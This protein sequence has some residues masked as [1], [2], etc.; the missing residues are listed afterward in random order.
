M[1][2]KSSVFGE[3]LLNEE[4]NF[5]RGKYKNEELSFR[6]CFIGKELDKL[7]QVITYAEDQIK[8]DFFTPMLLKIEDEMIQLKNDH[9]LEKDKETGRIESPI[10]TQQFRAQISITE[11][12]FQED[13]SS[14]IYCDIN[15]VF[16]GHVICIYVD[17]NGNYEGVGL[18]G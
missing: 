4:L 15:N 18:E 17:K 11:I 9:W 7:K 13:Y 8:K 1:I 2:I 6:V 12:V 10:T 14:I 5:F 3:L 16:W